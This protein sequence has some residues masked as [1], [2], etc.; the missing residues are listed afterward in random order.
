M[1]CGPRMNDSP[2]KLR[3]FFCV[4]LCFLNLH[5]VF[6]LW[7]FFSC[8]WC[9][10]QHVVLG[11]IS[12]WFLSTCS[13]F[14]VWSVFSVDSLYAGSAAR[15]AFLSIWCI[16]WF[17]SIGSSFPCAPC[18]RWTLFFFFRH[19]VSIKSPNCHPTVNFTVNGKSLIEKRLFLI[20]GP[21]VK[22]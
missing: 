13:P 21:T 4:I 20:F 5:A 18:F 11:R 19:F 1:A 6:F 17:P 3:P 14:S 7:L 2:A 22:K 15:S 10:S 9:V 12:F 16:L 8:V